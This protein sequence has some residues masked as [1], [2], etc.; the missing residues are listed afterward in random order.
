M[1]AKLFNPIL[2]SVYRAYLN[3][4]ENLRQRMPKSL[5]QSAQSFLNALGILID[6]YFNQKEY[7]KL[8]FLAEGLKD[9]P[10]CIDNNLHEAIVKR[11]Y[12]PYQRAKEMC[13]SHI[14]QGEGGKN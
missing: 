9:R 10:A 5:R 7:K 8:S 2:Y 4:P 1:I 11:L 3:M 6:K 14:G 13:P 12:H